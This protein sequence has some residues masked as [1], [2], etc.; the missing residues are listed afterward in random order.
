MVIVCCGGGGLLS[1]V[2]AG[3]KLKGCESTRIFG[4]EPEAGEQFYIYFAVK[5]FTTKWLKF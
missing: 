1:G 2:G 4:I 3:L 5:Y